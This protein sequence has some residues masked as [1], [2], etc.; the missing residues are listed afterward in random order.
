MSME[1]ARL[2]LSASQNEQNG[3]RPHSSLEY[4]TPLKVGGNRQ[5]QTLVQFE[6]LDS[7]TDLS[8]I[9]LRKVVSSDACH[10]ESNTEL[11]RSSPSLSRE[12][13]KGGESQKIDFEKSMDYG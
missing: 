10:R 6:I 2:K 1:D 4:H 13:D 8:K 9:R 12:G 5:R 3:E 7:L 11:S